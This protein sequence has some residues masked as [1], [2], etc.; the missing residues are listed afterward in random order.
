MT[1]DAEHKFTYRYEW[2]PFTGTW[3]GIVNWGD[4]KRV[5]EL[6]S[7]RYMTQFVN[8]CVAE[9]VNELREEIQILKE[10]NQRINNEF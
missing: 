3:V 1:I 9:I 6:T 7:A 10:E 5:R 4:F 8:D 2:D